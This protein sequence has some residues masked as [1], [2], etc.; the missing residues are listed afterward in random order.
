MTELIMEDMRLIFY[1]RN[2]IKVNINGYI[3]KFFKPINLISFHKLK[4]RIQF[5]NVLLIIIF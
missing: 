1:K 2:L 3:K 4:D 5:S